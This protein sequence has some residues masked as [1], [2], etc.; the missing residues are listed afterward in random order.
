MG[1]G[2][3]P[4]NV[5]LGKRRVAVSVEP[6]KERDL[7]RAF[8]GIKSIRDTLG[9]PS[10]T[11]LDS[12][13]L[14]DL[15][16]D[17]LLKHMG[18]LKLFIQDPAVNQFANNSFGKALAHFAFEDGSAR[19]ERGEKDWQGIDCK[20]VVYFGDTAYNFALIDVIGTTAFNRDGKKVELKPASWAYALKDSDITNLVRQNENVEELTN[21]GLLESTI[22]LGIP[23]AK[24]SSEFVRFL[25]Y[26]SSNP[27]GI[28]Y[29][30][31]L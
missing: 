31:Q 29:F 10:R 12:L 17:N 28:N 30:Q 4:R 5:L 19:I 11:M 14:A 7:R 8:A 23:K 25:P 1:R 9:E 26:F 13:S 6:E 22:Y 16:A 24:V 21:Q 15:T 2:S 3:N 18:T 20:E 27:D